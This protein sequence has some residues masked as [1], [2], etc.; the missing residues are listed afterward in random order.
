MAQ[1]IPA[2]AAALAARLPALSKHRNAQFATITVLYFL[3]GD[4]AMRRAVIAA[5]QQAASQPLPLWLQVTEAGRPLCRSMGFRDAA[6]MRL[7]V[8]QGAAH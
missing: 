3:Q 4:A 5:T 8:L 1:A 7:H 6:H 2:G